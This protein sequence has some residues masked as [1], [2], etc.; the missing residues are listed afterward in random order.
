MPTD[1]FKSM[2]AKTFPLGNTKILSKNMKHEFFFKV[3]NIDVTQQRNERKKL[4]NR[5][6]FIKSMICDKYKICF[7]LCTIVHLVPLFL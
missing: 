2:I 3:E 4:K 6:Y 1:L 5:T 7:F